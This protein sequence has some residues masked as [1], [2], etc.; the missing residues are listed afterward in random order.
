MNRCR[1]NVVKFK[2][3]NIFQ[4]IAIL[5]LNQVLV[6]IP[7]NMFVEKLGWSSKPTYREEFDSYSTYT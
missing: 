6:K 3:A 1:H 7:P 2:S 5:T 4:V